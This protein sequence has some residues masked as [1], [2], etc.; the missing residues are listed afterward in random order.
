MHT[1][2]PFSV[3]ADVP[4]TL[5]ILPLSVFRG[6][7]CEFLEGWE[8]DERTP[9]TFNENN[10]SSPAQKVLSSSTLFKRIKSQCTDA[11]RNKNVWNTYTMSTR[12]MHSVFLRTARFFCVFYPLCI[13]QCSGTGPST[14]D[15]RD[16][17]D[18]GD[19]KVRH[20]RVHAVK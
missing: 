20:M 2:T 13:R 9:Q 19:I 3:C 18:S 4:C 12:R 11:Y 1:L 6:S 16:P 8:E 7:R 5:S 17:S 15:G 14:D 10:E